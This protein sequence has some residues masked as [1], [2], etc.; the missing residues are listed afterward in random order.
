MKSD[1]PRPI[2]GMIL[3]AASFLLVTLIIL[4]TCSC[5]EPKQELPRIEG[6]RMEVDAYYFKKYSMHTNQWKPEVKAAYNRDMDK[7]RAE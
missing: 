1:N 5:S 7:A 2:L 4:L 3:L 6:T